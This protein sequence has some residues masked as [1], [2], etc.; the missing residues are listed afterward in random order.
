MQEITNHRNII[1][2]RIALLVFIGF[3]LGTPFAYSQ[4]GG[5]NYVKN[6]VYDESETAVGANVSYY[7]MFG[8]PAQAQV[9]NFAA[10]QV[11]AS[12]SIYDYR[13]RA[14]LTTLPAPINSSAFECKPD[15][16]T[17]TSNQRY[18]AADFDSSIDGPTSVG[19]SVLGS[20]GHYYSDQ[21]IDPEHKYVP[22]VNYP[23]VRSWIEDSPDPRTSKVAGPGDQLRM[24]AGHEGVVE[25][26]PLTQ[27]ELQ[28]YYQHRPVFTLGTYSLNE[29]LGYKDITTDPQGNQQVT[30]TDA[31]GKVLATGVK[32]GTSY[33]TWTYHY[34]NDA[35]QLV[36]TVAPKGILTTPMSFITKY[37]YDQLGRLIEVDSPDEGISRF[38]YATD[39]R[40]RFSQSAEQRSAAPK[41]FSYTNY[42]E[43][44]RLIESGEYTESGSG[45]NIFEPHT[46]LSAASNSVLNI[47]DDRGYTA[48]AHESMVA[49]VST[50]HYDLPD[51]NFGTE[52]NATFYT[53]QEFTMGQISYTENDEV[54]TWYSYDEMG[55]TTWMVQKIKGLSNKVVTVEYT[56]DFWG[57]VLQ[58]AYQ[59]GTPDAFYHHYEY[60]EDQRLKRVM[61]SLDGSMQGSSLYTHASY[62]YYLHGPLKRVELATDLQGIDYVYT[63][64]G[65]LKAINHPDRTQDPG[66][67]GAN[68]FVGDA[69]GQTLEYHNNDYSK[70]GSGIASVGTSAVAERFDGNLRAIAWGRDN[71]DV[72]VPAPD[73]IT[74]NAYQPDAIA[75]KAIILED[76][77]D[78]NDGSTDRD[79]EPTIDPIATEIPPDV[80][81]ELYAYSYDDKNQLLDAIY[82]QKSNPNQSVYTGDLAVT[83]NNRVQVTYED[84]NGNIGSLTRRDETGGVKHGLQYVYEATNN[85]LDE[86][87]GYA[88]Y[89]YN[90][91]GQLISVDYTDPGTPDMYLEYDPYGNVTAVYSDA[92]KANLKVSFAYDDK[93][94]R[95]K[96]ENHE[97]GI[98]TWYVRDAAGNILSMYYHDGTDLVQGELPIYGLSRI[99]IAF[100]TT[101]HY[102]YNYE[103]TDHL[104]NVRSVVTKLKF[105]E[106]ATMELDPQIQEVEERAFTNMGTRHEDPFGGANHTQTAGANRVVR[107]NPGEDY[108]D[109]N[110]MPKNRAIGPAKSLAVTY[111]DRVDID[112]WAYYEEPDN[113]NGLPA[114][115]I[116]PLVVESFDL[117]AG[118]GNPIFDGFDDAFN[119]MS[120]IALVP[121]ESS[122]VP[123]AYLQ[124]ILFD[125]SYTP[126]ASDYDKMTLNAHM[127]PNQEQLSLSV[128]IPA[129]ARY[130]YI[131]T[132]NESANNKD[133]YFDDFTVSHL[134]IDIIQTSSY[135]PFG[136]LMSHYVKQPDP[137]YEQE[138]Y[139]FGYQ[140]QYAEEDEETGWNAFQL[141]MYDPIIGRWLSPDPYGEFFSPYLAMGNNPR[142]VDPSGGCTTCP[143]ILLDDVVTVTA[144]ALSST[145][146]AI[147]GISGAITSQLYARS[148]R[149]LEFKGITGQ[150]DNTQLNQYWERP[151]SFLSLQ[152]KQ[153]NLLDGSSL[154]A[155]TPN[156]LNS[157]PQIIEANPAAGLLRAA[158][159][160]FEELV[161]LGLISGSVVGLLNGNNKQSQRSNIV[162]EI[163]AFNVIS[164]GPWQTQ[165][166]GVSSRRD[167]IRRSGNPRPEYQVVALNLNEFTVGEG[168]LLYGYRI[169]YRTANR[170]QALDLERRLVRQYQK[171]NNGFRPPLQIRP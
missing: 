164:G 48:S 50:I 25:R 171:R 161:A 102:K 168:Q 44:G 61:T 137:G 54:K 28:Y 154:N 11:L 27:N 135:Y 20:V 72:P 74:L 90:A 49:Y 99:G 69:F 163:F 15:F 156:F 128:N 119:A 30:Y 157:S 40:I 109:L 100:K 149:E 59:L 138:D 87:T 116:A 32:N 169:L 148:G 21:N 84:P 45:H 65:W 77:F 155:N 127:N 152:S 2:M 139:R 117:V 53:I 153:G 146:S 160:I 23:Y 166:Y 36:A 8:R 52:A 145:G 86:I 64:Q 101:S 13:G 51:P 29:D 108:V 96:K 42:D 83:N 5:V 112:V 88:D 151:N 26:T 162:Y 131:Y 34:Y 104:G 38:V 147:A 107:L 106:T 98:S 125:E 78:T 66:N 140:G 1:E 14:A 46:T 19:T 150:I 95:L 92:A 114:G 124:Y 93:G 144:S 47:V 6:T 9:K 133:V 122:T 103:I 142:L 111:G 71:L 130:M 80:G 37:K 70:A 12:Q 67:D 33:H 73:E 121:D 62:D 134:G 31:E 57:N 24:G 170:Q 113:G 123:K 85:R 10:N 39:G 143:T 3:V 159:I 94:F 165:K 115:G 105:M 136:S 63:A 82:E 22:A 68:S 17:N 129:N 4:G 141:R 89:T 126:I 118:E 35:G 41:R 81:A 76:G 132:V 16:I 7:D 79:F 60:D 97:S 91:I 167:F 18:S 43:A 110:G 58:V 56:Y 75:R 120:G 55:R 158:P